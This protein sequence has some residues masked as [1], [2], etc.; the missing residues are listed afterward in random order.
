[1]K[2]SAWTEVLFAGLLLVGPMRANAGMGRMCDITGNGTISSFDAV[3]VLQFI[4]GTRELT[5]EQQMLADAS[6][7]GVVTTYDAARIMQASTG[8][9]MPGSHCG[10]FVQLP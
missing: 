8:A 5:P 1:M 4:A 10:Q 7:N 9:V 3:Y 6:G 2:A